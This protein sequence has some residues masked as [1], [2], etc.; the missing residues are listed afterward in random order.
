M[1]NLES[2]KICE[3][4]WGKFEIL[5]TAKNYQVKIL[6]VY[7]NGILSLQ[8][9]KHRSEHWIIVSGTAKVTNG[10][11][12]AIF[13]ENESTFIPLGNIHRLEN[14]GK[15]NLEVIE[16][17]TGDYLGEDDIV[18]YE[19]IYNRKTDNSLLT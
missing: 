4:P 5:V 6:T 18:R 1:S 19:D 16:V 8:S 9:H 3:R 14:P 13:N 12:V 10:E 11:N 7:P 17:Q 2:E 15:K